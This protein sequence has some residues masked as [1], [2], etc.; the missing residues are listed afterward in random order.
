MNYAGFAK[1]LWTWLTGEWPA[2]HWLGI[3]WPSWP[4]LPGQS[5]V[6]TMRDYLA[7]PWPAL[8]ASF[9]LI[10]SHDTARIRTIT[11][12][13]ELVEV[14]VAALM[15]YPGT[16]MIWSG[17]EIGTEG[18]NGEHGRRPFPWHAPESWSSATLRA[19]QRLGRLRRT[20]PTL[21]SG[22]LRWVFV[23]ADRIVY[24]RET[25]WESAL[26]CLARRAGS[27]IRLPKRA[28][29]VHDGQQLETLYGTGV[30]ADDGAHVTVPGIGP[31]AHIWRWR[32]AG[33]SDSEQTH[34]TTP[35]QPE[36]DRWPR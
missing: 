13:E 14:A 23:D 1:P 36:E 5:V 11:G 33:P 16:P 24:L 31:A 8:L 28:L 17:D 9:T 7:V 2:E 21:Q 12:S 34:P 32:R 6:A 15:T 35:H 4:Q 10:G 22:G 19:Y 26:I 30:L 25:T 20:E 3:P 27:P 29:D 18:L